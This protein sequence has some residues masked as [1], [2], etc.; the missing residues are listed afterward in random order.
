[1]LR[2]G[3][4]VF[5]ELRDQWAQRIGANELE[6]LEDALSDLGILIPARFDAPGYFNNP[7]T[8]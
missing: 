8:A 7:T 3:E 6:R 2:T 4:Q 1:M 5:D